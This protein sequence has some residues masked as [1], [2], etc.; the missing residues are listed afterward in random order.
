M[1][2]SVVYYRNDSRTQLNITVA[3]NFYLWIT[4]IPQRVIIQVSITFFRSFSSSSSSKKKK[5]KKTSHVLKH[6]L[7]ISLEEDTYPYLH[8]QFRTWKN[9]TGT[10]KDADKFYLH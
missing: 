4:G 1:V 3:I 9:E 6:D 8:D 5:K 7:C 2:K 10:P